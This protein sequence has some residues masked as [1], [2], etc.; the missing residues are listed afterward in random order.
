MLTWQ[1]DLTNHPDVKRPCHR[2]STYAQRIVTPPKG[3]EGG[4]KIELKQRLLE[5]NGIGV[6]VIV[7]TS[8]VPNMVTDK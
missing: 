5:P 1:K 4:I 6:F 3:W 7:V 2:R 8:F